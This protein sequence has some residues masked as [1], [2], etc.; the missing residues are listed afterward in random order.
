MDLKEETILL[1]TEVERLTNFVEGIEYDDFVNPY[2]IMET[3]DIIRILLERLFI[4]SW[5]LENRY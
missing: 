2:K 1:R 4:L 5:E 3:Q